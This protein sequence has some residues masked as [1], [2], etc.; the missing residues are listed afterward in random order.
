MVPLL[1]VLFDAVGML[2]AYG[3]AVYLMGVDEGA[4]LQNV[5]K[6]LEPSDIMTGLVKA[7]VFGFILSV[8]SCYKGFFT[9]GGAR[10]VGRATTMAV[11]LSS[12]SI[13]VAD[14][15]LTEFMY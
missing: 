8:I 14:Y 3:V 7:G 5:Q 1:T 13:F 9:T 12:V 4:F 15:I 11:V 6:Y 10:G 2:G